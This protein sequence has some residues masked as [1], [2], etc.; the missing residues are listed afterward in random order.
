MRKRRH[1][2]M[3]EIEKKQSFLEQKKEAKERR[4]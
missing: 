3:V 1:G 2:S 4:G